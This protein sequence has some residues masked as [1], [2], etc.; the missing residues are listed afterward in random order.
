MDERLISKKELSERL[1]ISHTQFNK[2]S[3][4]ITSYKLGE[5]KRGYLWSEVLNDLR[6]DPII[7]KPKVGFR[8]NGLKLVEIHST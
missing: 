4:K 3:H 8:H 7:E 2:I 5:S 6:S 1:G